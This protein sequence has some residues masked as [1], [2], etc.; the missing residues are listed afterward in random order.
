MNVGPVEILFG[1]AIVVGAIYLVVRF[2]TQD[3]RG[4][5]DQ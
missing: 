4:R 2:A 1:L 5:D 3:R